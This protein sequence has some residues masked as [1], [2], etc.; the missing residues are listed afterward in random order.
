MLCYTAI[1]KAF[2]PTVNQVGHIDILL[3]MLVSKHWTVIWKLLCST[4]IGK[5]V[6]TSSSTVLR[7]KCRKVSKMHLP[8]LSSHHAITPVYNSFACCTFTPFQ[9]IL[10]RHKC[11]VFKMSSS[12]CPFNFVWMFQDCGTGTVSV[13]WQCCQLCCSH[14]RHKL[15]G[16]VRWWRLKRMIINFTFIKFVRKSLNLFF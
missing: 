2:G 5:L 4:S 7:P 11:G 6:V 10:W 9:R 1:S 8:I 15:L 14:C 16:L 3:F 12:A 13:L